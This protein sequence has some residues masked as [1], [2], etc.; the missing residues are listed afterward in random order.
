MRDLSLLFVLATL[1]SAA[2]YRP[3]LGVLG[4]AVVGFMAPHAYGDS[5]ASFPAYLVLFAATVVATV[6]RRE[7]RLPAWD[8]Y[9]GWLLVL[10]VWFL[11]T[12]FYAM[13]PYAAWP[14]FIEVS[15]SLLPLFL[16]LILIDTREKLFYL[17]ATI[18][19]AFTLV[20]LKGSYWALM[21]GFTDRVYGPPGSHFYDNNQFAVAI[22]MILPFL[23][24]WIRSTSDEGLRWGLRAAIALSTAAALSS[25]SRG[26][27]I[28]ILVT[29][30]M[31][32]WQSRQR[33][34]NISLLVATV[35]LAWVAMPEQWSTRMQSVATYEVDD[36][37]QSRLRA[38]RAGFSYAMRH[39]FTGGG[40][41]GW[42]HVMQ[43]E[44]DWH[45]SYVEILVEHGF[46]G[47]TLWSALILTALLRLARIARRGLQQPELSW[48][49]E[50]ALAIS[51]SLAAY[52]A[53]G[54]FLGITYWDLLFHLLIL[55]VLLERFSAQ[56]ATTD[57]T[58]R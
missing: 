52:A 55:S 27:V 29:T 51:T 53:G 44:V 45:N 33:V 15:K 43:G 31:L 46:I 8:W 25:W 32:A 2:F 5:M 39:P 21:T 58:S 34:L 47:F 38:W 7:W 1:A 19:L 9:L 24:M 49:R 23:V 20:T 37:A 36:S 50:H 57:R 16:T 3:W 48:A 56:T 30:M 6:L 13:A 11:I 18:V 4:L 10:W 28:A 41:E 14:R 17:I 22:A 54:L 42:Q 40:F 35:A 12:T 26:G